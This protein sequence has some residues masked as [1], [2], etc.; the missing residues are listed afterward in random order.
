[1]IAVVTHL[2]KDP[3]GLI[4]Q[5]A[6]EKYRPFPFQSTITAP[7][8]PNRPSGQGKAQM[9]GLYGVQSTQ[10]QSY[11]F[12]VRT[13][14]NVLDRMSWQLKPP[15]DEIFSAQ[16]VR[17]N[18]RFAPYLKE[19]SLMKGT[20]FGAES[21]TPMI[22]ESKK[23]SGN[24]VW[25]WAERES[26]HSHIIH[27]R[28]KKEGAT[29][30]L[31]DLENHHVP[32]SLS[33]SSGTSMREDDGKN[34]MFFSSGAKKVWWTSRPSSAAPVTASRGIPS[35]TS[36]S[37]AATTA[38]LDSYL[39]SGLNGDGGDP[40]DLDLEF[41]FGADDKDEDLFAALSPSNIQADPG[42]KAGLKDSASESVCRLG[43]PITE[44]LFS[45]STDYQY[46]WA[47]SGEGRP[48]QPAG[49]KG[50]NAI[51]ASMKAAISESESRKAATPPL[52][53]NKIVKYYTVYLISASL[54]AKPCL[55]VILRLTDDIS[56]T[57]H[58]LNFLP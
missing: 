4:A 51:I 32:V 14:K 11:P 29:L 19:F 58:L 44:R 56:H 1:M 41:G 17:T 26:V 3:Y 25:S 47:Q 46:D 50:M 24:G 15:Q 57:F 21:G 38:D 39:F 20:D 37:S 33:S 8:L 12:P 30:S 7:S 43:R 23:E 40:D 55:L 53:G 9:G 36:S 52:P 42:D 6:L 35:P 49:T 27:K 31:V 22:L 10:N 5:K 13:S 16:E 34:G 18:A 48:S 54:R 45:C 2:F 28:I